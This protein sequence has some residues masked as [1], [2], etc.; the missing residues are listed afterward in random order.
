MC[1]LAGIIE[2]GI[3]A[4]PTETRLRGMTRAI[5]HRGPDADGH[6]L[7]KDRGV[8][9]GHRRLS[10]LDLSPAGAQPMHS[11]CG[12]FVIAFNGEIY[13]HL[14]LR[15]VLEQSR[16][17]PAWRG[18][19]D[20]ETLLASIAHWGLEGALQKARGMFALALWDRRERALS[21]AR[22]R[23]GEK[24]LYFAEQEN[25]WLF[26]SEL[27]ALIAAGLAARIDRPALA[28][29]LRLGY[30]PDHLCILEGVRKVMPGGIA[31]LR[32]GG[33]PELMR[34]DSIK[35]SFGRR[36]T[37]TDSDEA[38]NA[39]E[40]VM[41]EVVGEQML[42]DVPLGCFLSGG[43]DSSLVAS[44]MQAGSDR[45]I[46]SFSIGFEDP[47]FNEAPHAA[48]VASHLG[49][50]HTE[51]TL[52]E[53][54]ALAIV[55]EL[56]RIYDE[57][58]ADSSQIPT[59][60]LCR[61]AREHVTVALTGDGGDEV[62]GGYNRHIR[63]PG[64]W[65]KIA[66]IPGMLR[67]A[68]ASA[69][70]GGAWLGRRH[71]WATRRAIGA[72]G[73]PLT[74]VD[75]LPKLATA[76]RS[77]DD[78]ET[79][80]Q[81]FIAIGPELDDVLQSPIPAIPP[82]PRARHPDDMAMVEW[83]MARDTTG[84]LPGDI[85]V[86]LD[87]AAMSV[88]LE[89]RAPFLDARVSDLARQIPVALHVDGREGKK[90]VRALLYRHVPRALIERPKQGFAMPVDDWLR[91]ALKHWAGAL[92]ADEGPVSALGLNKSTLM[93]LWHNHQRRRVNAGRQLWVLLMLLLWAKDMAIEAGSAGS[94]AGAPFGRSGTAHVRSETVRD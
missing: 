87:R 35:K 16:A 68:A 63:G 65:S 9:L 29:Y 36:P 27:R 77:A 55:P 71:E 19:S 88:S 64:L 20:T 21:L 1:G 11:A 45:Q 93:A 74:T 57:P 66:R 59:T 23:M 28:A 89:T 67:P 7:D 79:F 14:A 83:L 80:Y 47:R 50:A 81:S 40:Q 49:T 72:L 3:L 46:H 38:V 44:L 90:L 6:W 62:F 18:H 54:D 34:Y 52:R 5:T 58:F 33:Q 17:A 24:P 42:S 15:R 94:C 56:S 4:D 73:L 61:S 48:A 22:D 51:F 8:A 76:L 39:L 43:V 60:L 10:I 78:A 30:V 13:N 69:V 82:D 53:E 86:K 25:G 2:T 85:L 41:E 12:R 92:I 26:G 84:Y 75:N 32:P 31:V 91:G 37:I 70:A